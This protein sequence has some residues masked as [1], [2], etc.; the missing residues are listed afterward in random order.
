M[1]K[2]MRMRPVALL[3]AAAT[4]AAMAAT[5]VVAAPG[6]AA[7]GE[8]EYTTSF[9]MDCV[10]AP[11]V[12]NIH[13]KEKLKVTLSAT[14]PEQVAVGQELSFHGAHAT[15]ES[16]VELTE[17]F[18]SLGANEVKGAATLFVLTG[19]GGGV[20]PDSINIVRPP[21][22]PNGL[23]F[24]AP[25]EKGKPSIFHIPSLTLGETGLT[26]SFGP[27]KATSTSGSVVLNVNSEPGYEEVEPGSFKET[28]K[29]IITELEGRNSGAHVVG[30]LKTACNAPA[31][32]VAASIP[33][34]GGPCAGTCT[35][36]STT[37]TV[38]TGCGGGPVTCTTTTTTTTAA[39]KTSC[40]CVAGKF[41]NW[42]LT[43]ALTDKK[44]GEKITLPE[45]C[46]FNGEFE[47]P[48]PMEGNTL[49]PPF[50]ASVKLFGVLPMTLG[51]TLAESEPIKGVFAAGSGG[52]IR[53]TGTAKDNLGFSS[54]GVLGLTIPTSCRTS[55]PVVF[56]LETEE[57]PAEVAQRITFDGDAALPSIKCSG[58]FL[59]S[60]FGQI[61]TA[62][63]SGPNN[64][65]TLTTEP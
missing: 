64:P 44:L 11:G 25:V 49:C 8:K 26:Y 57:R 60:L 10:V 7:A 50:K 9:E 13:A 18:V 36:T 32:V 5:L 65:F 46:T 51:L 56:P 61:V 38:F 47:L 31:G 19:A 52:E 1:L 2:G 17:S 59:S 55:E 3:V 40:A 15:I 37:A 24:L 62:L 4:A 42:K 45:G 43:G 53:I 35:T 58:G 16:P 33:I 39:T 20:E 29:G 27:L 22:F 48:G 54:V 34:N 12:L 30:P 28:G 63:M 6:G 21:E 14:G 41:E 23:P